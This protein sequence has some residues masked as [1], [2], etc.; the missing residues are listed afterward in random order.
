MRKP[1]ILTIAVQ[2]HLLFQ[3]FLCLVVIL[4]HH[5]VQ[6]KG[7][8]WKQNATVLFNH[9]FDLFIL[10]LS[11][12]VNNEFLVILEYNNS[13]LLKDMSKIDNFWFRRINHGMKRINFFNLRTKM[14]FDNFS[15]NINNT[16]IIDFLKISMIHA[17][18]FLF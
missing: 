4:V 7:V 1:K 3:L 16:I 17:F 2:S 14:I 6:F 8:F 5:H 13:K 12:K 18:L 15:K 10:E 9:H 11:N